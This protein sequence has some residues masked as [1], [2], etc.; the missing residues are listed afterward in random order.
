MK[1]MQTYI[2]RSKKQ[3]I[4]TLQHLAGKPKVRIA[5]AGTNFS[6]EPAAGI[7]KWWCKKLINR[8]KQTPQSNVG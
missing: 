1:P 3:M 8:I 7:D 5:L 2:V 6:F 4:A